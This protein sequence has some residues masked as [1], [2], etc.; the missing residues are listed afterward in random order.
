MS[1]DKEYSNELITHMDGMAE[2]I[3][4]RI[5]NQ[6]FGIPISQVREVFTPEAITNVPLSPKEIA[7]VL[8]LRGM[9][10]TAV[11]MRM[12]L[13]LP[14]QEQGASYMAV[15][16]DDHAESYCLLV[17]SVEEVMRLPKESKEPS[18][19]AVQERWSHFTS[20][21]HLLDGQL[22]VILNIHNVLNFNKEAA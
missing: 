12:R 4:V 22:L 21:V 5:M 18:P 20:G 8:N 1:F 11:D 3:T 16:I 14:P 17:D 10:V 19:L 13:S 2:Y 9:I 7:G 6:L 15:G